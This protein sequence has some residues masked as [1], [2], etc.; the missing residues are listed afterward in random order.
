[1][2]DTMEIIKKPNGKFEVSSIA[3]V[4]EADMLDRRSHAIRRVRHFEKALIA[5]AED[6]KAIE[7]NLVD[8]KALLA[9][10][11]TVLGKTAEDTIEGEPNGKKNI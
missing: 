5:N 1:M 3:E 9:K 4:D 2:R 7:D 8:S 6:K 10:I 11:N